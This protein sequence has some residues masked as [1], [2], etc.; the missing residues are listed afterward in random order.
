[1]ATSTVEDYLKT[2]LLKSTGDELV[3]MGKIAEGLG[4]VPGTVTTM[5]K[6]LADQ[7]LIEHYPRQGVRLTERGSLHLT[8]CASTG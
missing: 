2:I 4:V 5:M 3:S 8:C 7:A 1:M 6:S